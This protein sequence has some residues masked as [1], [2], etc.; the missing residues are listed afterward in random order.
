MRAMHAPVLS[1]TMIYPGYWVWPSSLYNLTK[2][3]AS[4]H[5]KENT[6]QDKPLPIKNH[7]E[8][9]LPK[10]RLVLSRNRF[11]SQLLNSVLGTVG[12]GC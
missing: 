9:Q 8:T 2:K 11:A 1:A 10:R 5:Q 6:T 12:L 7:R 3:K 4:I